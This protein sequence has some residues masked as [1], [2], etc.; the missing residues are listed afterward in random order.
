MTKVLIVVDMLN[1]FVHG[2]GALFFEAGNAIIPAVKRRIA[3]HR[4]DGSKIIY[5]NDAHDKDDK[6]FE[7]FPPHAIKDTWGAE[8]VDELAPVRGDV[9]IPKK[10]YSGF[11]GTNLDVHT[12]HSLIDKNEIEVIGVCTSIC[13]MDTVGDLA[14]RDIKATVPADAVAD[15]N[16]AAHVA[17]LDR[18]AAIYGADVTGL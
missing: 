17:A 13:V 2:D 1:D 5:I 10:R 18:M 6:E 4:A 8:V 15:F 7:R 11:Y 12:V 3:A 9:V 14:N 16:P